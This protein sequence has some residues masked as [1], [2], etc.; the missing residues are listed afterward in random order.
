MSKG[1]AKPKPKPKPK[2]KS[3]SEIRSDKKYGVDKAPK[4]GLKTEA[5]KDTGKGFNTRQGKKVSGRTRLGEA[6]DALGIYKGK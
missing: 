1:K 5:K 2:P 3:A 4:K 6:P